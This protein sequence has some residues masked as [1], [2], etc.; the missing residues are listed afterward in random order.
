MALRRLRMGV[1]GGVA[2]AVRPEGGLAR[3]ERRPMGV[4]VL[5]MAGKVDER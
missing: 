2:G 3:K 4:N 5:L 1:K